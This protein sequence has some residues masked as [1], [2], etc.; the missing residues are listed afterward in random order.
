MLRASFFDRFVEVRQRRS[1]AA[2][3][4]S[5]ILLSDRAVDPSAAIEAVLSERSVDLELIILDDASEA[6]TADRLA[7]A[8]AAD[9][10]VLLIRYQRRTGIPALCLNTALRHASGRFIG[11]QSSDA[12]YVPGGLAALVAA[13]DGG[14]AGLVHGRIVKPNGPRP[15]RDSAP[16]VNASVLAGRNPLV[17]AG[18]LHRPDVIDRAGAF[19]PHLAIRGRHEWDLWQRIAEGGVFVG[20]PDEVAT[21]L[22]RADPDRRKPPSRKGFALAR[23]R[24]DRTDELSLDGA[25]HCDVIGERFLPDPASRIAFH[26]REI[27]P[28]LGAHFDQTE[29][30][31][32]QLAARLLPEERAVVSVSG[33]VRSATVEM[34]FRNYAETF[35]AAIGLVED[36]APPIHDMT[37]NLRT[38]TPPNADQRAKA[39]AERKPLIYALDDDLFALYGRRAENAPILHAVEDHT[40]AADLVIVYA[41]A[42]IEHAAALNP[43]VSALAMN[44]PARFIERCVDGEKERGKTRYLL[45]GRVIRGRELRKLGDELR[46]FFNAHRGEATLTVFSDERLDP[47]YRELLSGIDYETTP[48]LH[49]RRFREFL[50]GSTFHFLINPLRESRFNRGKSPVKYLEATMAGA[51]LITSKA[52]VYRQVKHGETGI[53]VPWRT[54]AWRE[55]LEESLAMGEGERAA[56][57]AAAAADIGSTRSTE[58]TYLTFRTTLE[59]AQ[60]HALL[61]SRLRPGGKALIVVDDP[62]R[63]GLPESLR[64]LLDP[65]H[66]TVVI[67]DDLAA[68]SPG[69]R[70]ETLKENGAALVH[71]ATLRSPWLAAATEAG[72]PSVSGIDSADELRPPIARPLAGDPDCIAAVTADLAGSAE[73]AGFARSFRWT[74]SLPRPKKFAQNSLHRQR[75]GVRIA[76]ASGRDIAS[77]AELIAASLQAFA[78]DTPVRLEIACGADDQNAW[79]TALAVHAVR[80][81]PVFVEGKALSRRAVLLTLGDGDDLRRATLEA[82]SVGVPVISVRGDVGPRGDDGLRDCDVSP[83]PEAV[84]TA[85][86]RLYALR[87]RRLQTLRRG[88]AAT[89]FTLA[90]PDV[91]AANLI[92]LYRIAV[93]ASDRRQ[94]RRRLEAQQSRRQRA[95]TIDVRDGRARFLGFTSTEPLAPEII[96]ADI[97]DHWLAREAD[98]AVEVIAAAGGAARFIVAAEDPSVGLAPAGKGEVRVVVTCDAISREIV[99]G[100]EMWTP[101]G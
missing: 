41:R 36:E 64:S 58:A 42:L 51:V 86:R 62:A 10:R 1:Q 13:I 6:E 11:Y 88:A 40:R 76:A 12:Y 29:L 8:H 59:A 101:L 2:P 56:M 52:H 93:E 95:V 68:S 100:E 14:G 79:R 43:R 24:A 65:L 25:S 78:G 4:V 73:Q 72:I 83:E 15:H 33:S 91:A 81:E 53:V 3:V 35:P 98:G 7:S 85:L 16:E 97:P 30:L 54:G 87:P 28:Y 92:R 34:A 47:E 66:F 39:L 18:V 31:E 37:V 89:A 74:P 63:T 82:M 69:E 17:A 96:E 99:A 19:D 22:P 60:L 27:L 45:I 55:A 26:S 71:A 46:D 49:Y 48:L 61:R 9:D 38:L 57:H 70:A 80:P 84:A 44:T 90:D 50:V 5:V 75:G 77:D 21:V 67:A 32:T 23:M 20:I 94:A